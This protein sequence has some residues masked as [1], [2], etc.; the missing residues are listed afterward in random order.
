MML[1]EYSGKTHFVSRSTNIY[2]IQAKSNILHFQYSET[3]I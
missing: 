3:W 2:K 1:Q